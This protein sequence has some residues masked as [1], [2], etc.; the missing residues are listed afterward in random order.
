MAYVVDSSIAW[1]EKDE[2]RYPDHQKMLP[3]WD[4]DAG[5]WQRVKSIGK[6]PQYM[7]QQDW[8]FYIPYLHAWCIIRENFVHDWA[9]I[10]RLLTAVTSPDGVLAAG[11]PPHDHGYRFGGLFLAQDMYEPF[12]FVELS[13]AELDIMFREQNNWYNG[14]PH[15]NYAAYL[16]LRAWGWAN[17]KPRD[18]ENVDWSK[19]VYSATGM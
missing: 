18:I 5:Y 11:A 6:R 10:P 19:P 17:F 2:K 14:L 7:F 13:R 4:N 9:S 15:S 1:P 8:I 3:M 12:D 16:A